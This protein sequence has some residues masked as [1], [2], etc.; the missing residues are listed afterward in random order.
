VRTGESRL[1][2]SGGRAL[3]STPVP[4]RLLTLLAVALVALVAS[5]CTEGTTAAV[6]VGDRT[7]SHRDVIDELDEWAGNPEAVSSP[8]L[9]RGPAPGSYSTAFV[10]DLVGFRIERELVRAEAERRG[11]EAGPE[12]IAAARQAFYGDEA[13]A[14]AIEAGW[15]EG[16]AARLLEDIALE[17]AL[18]DELGQAEFLAWR[19]AAA[20]TDRISVSSRLGRWDDD[21]GRVV[22][23][24]GPVTPAGDDLTFDL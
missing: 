13:T 24:E 6:R 14:E 10:A 7:L 8:E 5:G 1:S 9:L 2:P 12:L 17:L 15:S 4:R 20:S 3:R 21:Q 18:Q 23:P 22:P 16:Y 19:D 11:L